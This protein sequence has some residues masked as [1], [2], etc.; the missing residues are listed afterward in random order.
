MPTRSRKQEKQ[1]TRYKKKHAHKKGCDFCEINEGVDHFISESKSF[2][3]FRNIFPYS[4]WDDQDVEE[5][6]LM[7]PKRHVDTLD[8][9]TA[10]EAVEFINL[11]SS[12]ENQGYNVY[13]RA[14]QSSIK[15]VSHQHTHLIKPASKTHNFLFVL[16]KPYIRIA[17]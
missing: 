9:L 17:R 3:T 11:I 5:H 13:M 4:V 6:L 15:S 16:R 12:Y 14:P 1:Y 8:E 10:P 7:T 2:K